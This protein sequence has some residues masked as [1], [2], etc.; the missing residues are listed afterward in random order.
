M[1]SSNREPMTEAQQE[2][3]KLLSEEAGE[4]F[5]GSLDEAAATQRIE[6]L[7]EQSGRGVHERDPDEPLETA[8]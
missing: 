5:D 4:P 3:L 1:V 8:E 6:E 7:R 2:Y